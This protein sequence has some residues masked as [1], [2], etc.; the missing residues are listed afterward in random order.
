[1]Y[2]DR[3]AGELGPIIQNEQDLT[4]IRGRARAVAD[5]SVYAK[6]AMNNLGNYV[7]GRGLMY[8]AIRRRNV[9][10]TIDESV[11]SAVNKV[12]NEFLQRSKWGM[13]SRR[14]RILRR[15][16]RDG[17][18]LTAIYPVGDG[19]CNVRLLEPGLLRA[20]IDQR[21]LQ[22]G[23]NWGFGVHTDE[24]D[25]ETIFGYNVQWSDK[26]DDFTYFRPQ[27]FHHVCCN[28]D[29]DVKRGLS[30]FYPVERYLRHAGKLLENTVIGG[31]ILAAIAM[32]VEHT[33]GVNQASAE[34]FTAG[35]K[36]DSQTEQTPSGQR[37]KTI[38]KYNPGTIAH[39]P[40]GQQYKSTPLANRGVGDSMVVIN[41][42]VLRTVGTN[43]SMPEYMIS[44]DA[45]NN[46]YASI[47][48][49]G[50]PFV[51][52]VTGIQGECAEQD[53]ELLWKVLQVAHQA[54]KFGGVDFEQLQAELEIQIE[55]PQVARTLSPEDTTRRATLYEKGAMSMRTWQ[56]QED[57]DPD[58]EAEY[59]A[60]PQAVDAEPLQTADP[61]PIDQPQI[62]Q[63]PVGDAGLQTDLTLNG[64]QV[65][66]AIDLLGRVALG[67]IASEAALE[68][69]VGIG[70]ERTLAQKM[71]SAQ[72]KIPPQQAATEPTKVA[73]VPTSESLAE[74]SRRAWKGYP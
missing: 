55:A 48:E 2:A 37:T 31:S 10:Q 41:Q 27:R 58:V 39:V 13:A 43:W 66:A 68:L 65:T 45:S 64:A 49:S 26:P 19:R 44:G 40:S 24:E 30:D 9:E 73:A 74:A 8:K 51:L 14:K 12:V 53:S 54:K 21:Q 4:T 3:K 71:L 72:A 36:Y 5:V 46:N 67:G 1:M 42:A 50:T 17:E 61:T 56:S 25:P 29:D 11:V 32:I 34:S 7:V 16:R 6:S 70:V 60:K 69:L 35:Q 22:E 28:V 63:Q 57:L 52:F 15:T 18:L 33:P 59:G 20:P 62:A 47:L 38:Q 23:G